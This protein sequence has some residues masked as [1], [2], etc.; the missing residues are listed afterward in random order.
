MNLTLR[1]IIPGST[2]FTVW[3]M[4]DLTTRFVRVLQSQLDLYHVTPGADAPGRPDPQAVFILAGGG[5][6]RL[7]TTDGW[8]SLGDCWEEPFRRNAAGVV[9]Q[10]RLVIAASNEYGWGYGR[11]HYDQ[12]AGGESRV[13]GFR[14]NSVQSVALED[15][16]TASLPS[17]QFSRGLTPKLDSVTVAV[18][19]ELC[20]VQRS[21]VDKI[22][23]N[24]RSVTFDDN[25]EG[26]VNLATTLTLSHIMGSGSR[27]YLGC[28]GVEGSSFFA[29]MT[30]NA[31]AE[32]LVERAKIGVNYDANNLVYYDLVN[33]TGGTTQN[34]VLTSTDAAPICGGAVSASGVDQSSPRSSTPNTATGTSATPS[35]Q[36]DSASGE[37]VLTAVTFPNGSSPGTTDA[38]Y[39][40][41][42]PIAHT[43][44][45]TQNNSGNDLWLRVAHIA[46]DTSIT[47]TDSLTASG[48]WKMIGVAVKQWV[49][50]VPLDVASNSGYKT[51]SSSYS[52]NHTCTGANLMLLVHI[53]MLTSAGASV[54]GITYNGVAMSLIAAV[55]SG[56]GAIRIETW[57]L[58][59]PATGT[60]SIAV[61]LSASLDS[62]GGA[63]S[64]TGV[65][66]QAPTAGSATATATNV[67]AADAT[68]SLTPTTDSDVKVVGAV[69]TD[70]TAI[71][72]GAG[73]T[74][75]HNVTGTSGSGAASDESQ[76]ESRASTTIS[77]TDVAA[78]KTWSISAVALRPVSAVSGI[79]RNFLAAKAS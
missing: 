79:A 64:Y 68:V 55:S 1:Q 47:R 61:T 18:P 17:F 13:Q 15:Y 8:P 14:Y 20:E 73:Q 75:Q 30:W 60:N 26:N 19:S 33:P 78:L 12:P 28:F 53:S 9:T 38:S 2:A 27:R 6:A 16:S 72:V 62:V 7:N 29:G 58:E 3:I 49:D 46:G 74:A 48:A 42:V 36:E 43:I 41:G 32:A 25:S 54:T 45:A 71:T 34:I 70:D 44:D 50:P 52:W 10:K 4:P 35:V 21:S 69:A 5:G 77:W 67:G 40:S 59:N 22:V 31:A 65:H 24:H 37:L 23:K 57:G 63:E 76:S 56:V 39:T 66:Q 51:A 11:S